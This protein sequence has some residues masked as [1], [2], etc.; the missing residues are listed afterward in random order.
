[1]VGYFYNPNIH[2][3]EEYLRRLEA[4]RKVA[5]FFEVPLLEDEYNPED[6]W[7]EIQ[8]WEEEPEGGKRCEICFRLRLERTFKKMKEEN[9]PLFTTTLTVSP[10]KKVTAINRIGEEIGKE[11]FLVRIFRKQDGFKKAI[12]WA[13]K[14]SLYRQNYCG[15]LL[16][17]R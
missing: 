15:C 14:L 5:D 2:P 9:I 1:V 13:K 17:R 3:E 11:K 16:S 6:W 12:E 4:A 10:H 7:K 8:G